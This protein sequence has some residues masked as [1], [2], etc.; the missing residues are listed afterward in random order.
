MPVCHCLLPCSS[1]IE[2]VAAPPPAAPV[3]PEPRAQGRPAATG[4][5]LGDELAGGA[6]AGEAVP[7]R[8]EALAAAVVVHAVVGAAAVGRLALVHVDAELLVDGRGGEPLPAGALEGAGR[9]VAQVL[10]PSAVDLG[11]VG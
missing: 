5:G 11:W 8:A 2:R 9:V 6:V 3:V 4:G 7:G 1:R 10:A